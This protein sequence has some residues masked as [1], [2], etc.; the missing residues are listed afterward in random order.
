MAITSAQQS[1]VFKL[2]VGLFNAAPGGFYNSVAGIL[3]SSKDAAAAADALI[4]TDAFQA[5]IPSTC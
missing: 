1:A 5:I 3:L 2:A 4:A